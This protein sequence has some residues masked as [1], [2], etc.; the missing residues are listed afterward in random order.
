M[1]L[2]TDPEG[3]I[4]YVN[5]AFEAVTGYTRREA[6]GQTPRLLKS[7]RQNEA[8]YRN[9]W[10]TIAGGRVWQGRMVNKRKDGTLYTEETTIS[11]V[12]DGSGRIVSFVAVKRDITEHLRISQE[13]TRLQE[14]LQQAQKMESIGRLAGGVAHD[15]NNLLSIIFGYGDIIVYQKLHPSDPLREDVEEILK[16]GRRS[17]DLTRQLLACSRKQTLQPE[18]LD[19][20]EVIRNIE[21]MLRRLIGED[22]ALDLSLSWK[23]RV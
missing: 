18:E 13:Q 6:I 19:L 20:N 21:K 12:K 7:G 8:F 5:P 3:T 16:P 23:K 9:L 1:I 10:D 4:Q 17:A 14:Q 15:F 11:P 2:V 22:I